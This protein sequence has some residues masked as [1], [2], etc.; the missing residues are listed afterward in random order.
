MTTIFTGSGSSPLSRGI[1]RRRQDPAQARRIIPALAGNTSSLG[2]FLGQEP[3]HPRSRGE[4]LSTHPMTVSTLG[5]SPLSRGILRS[6]MKCQRNLR[7]I[8]ALAGNTCGLRRSRSRRR[9]HP[10][11]RGEYIW[12]HDP[13]A[14]D[15]GSSP[16]SRG[17]PKRW[18]WRVRGARIIPALA[19]NTLA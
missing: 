15:D 5:S 13:H 17:I 19:G 2:R 10:R 9:D 12:A 14:A 6:L 7:I 8:P 11:S 3:D 16:L 4:Y 18:W 1:H